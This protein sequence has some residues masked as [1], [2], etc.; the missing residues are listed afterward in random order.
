[1]KYSF[2]ILILFI[3]F[4]FTKKEDFKNKNPCVDFLSNKDYLI[5]MIPHHQV[6]IDMC[7]LMKPISKSKT[8]LNIYRKIIWNQNIEINLMKNVLNGIPNITNE[9]KSLFRDLNFFTS[10]SNNTKSK[11]KNY[12]CDPLFFKPNNHKVHM[13]HMKHT[14]KSFL[15]HMIPHHQVA[16]IMSERLIKHTNN[17]HMLRI[18]YEIITSQ[19][20]EILEMNYIL[21]YLNHNKID[22]LPNYL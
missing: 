12:Y 9:S 22:L 14:D 13:N 15:E 11:P 7:K 3:F 6:A 2:L 20:Y 8:M 5:H 1:M 10:I 21:D 16:I 4:I 19:R 17:T 18:C